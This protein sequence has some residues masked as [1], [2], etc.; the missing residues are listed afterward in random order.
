MQVEYHR[1]DVDFIAH[2][3]RWAPVSHIVKK[4]RNGVISSECDEYFW[5]ELTRQELEDLVGYLCYEANH[6]NRKKVAER[7]GELVDGFEVQLRY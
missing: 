7:V 2:V 5:C 6:N 4:L 3:I 1:D